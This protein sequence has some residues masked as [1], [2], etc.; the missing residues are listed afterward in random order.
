MKRNVLLLMLV[1]FN[2]LLF[3]QCN[4]CDSEQ[5]DDKIFTPQEL[6]IVPYNT[7]E[8]YVFKDTLNDSMIYIVKG[9]WSERIGPCYENY[10]NYD[11]EC[12]GDYCYYINNQGSVGCTEQ[13]GEIQFKLYYFT[14]YSTFSFIKTIRLS[15]NYTIVQQWIFDGAF[16]FSDQN[17]T[18]KN[19]SDGKIMSFDSTLNLGPKTFNSVYTLVKDNFSLKTVYYNFSQGV[20]GFKSSD[21]H[22]WYLAN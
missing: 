10:T 7:G 8:K 15:I 22:L 2:T 16:Y 21:G 20:V 14:P 3:V 5:L 12:K 9:R 18:E 1:I 4:K 17:L 13:A 6:A 19:S 11:A